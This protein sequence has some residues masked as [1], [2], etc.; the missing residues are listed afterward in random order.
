EIGELPA[1]VQALLLRV[2]Q[3][4]VIERVG[5][6]SVAIEVRVI[7]ATHRDLFAET[8]QGRFRTDL[9]YRLNVFPIRVPPLRDRRDDIP[10]LTDHFL[11]MAEVKYQRSQLRVS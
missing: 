5:G 7:A 2:L 11:R 8:K 9:F 10:E 6:G 1:D 3:E 4:R